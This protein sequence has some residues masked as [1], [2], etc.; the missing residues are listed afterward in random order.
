MKSYNRVMLVGHL[1]ADPEM[2][3]TKNGRNVTNFPIAINRK[4]LDS[5]GNK[6][7]V[8]DFHRVV[9]WQRLG[10]ICKKYLRKGMPILL[11]GRLVNVSFEPENG[12]KQY[13]T[14]IIAE[15]LQILSWKKSQS[16]TNEVSIDPVV[17]S[18]EKELVEV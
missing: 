7:E 2:R 9:A 4:S 15:S 17:G 11:E 14:E 18:E 16:G 6:Q 1:A 5:K 12:K 10:E 13:R 3:K 8:A